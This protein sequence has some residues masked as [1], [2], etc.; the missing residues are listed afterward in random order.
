[1]TARPT[2]T[3]DCWG[4]SCSQTQATMIGGKA[5]SV[6]AWIPHQH[7]F[8]SKTAE[9]DEFEWA[10]NELADMCRTRRLRSRQSWRSLPK[11]AAIRLSLT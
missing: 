2:M 8:N 6:A 4:L 1:M 9:V 10:M 5:D 3:K 7:I 11:T